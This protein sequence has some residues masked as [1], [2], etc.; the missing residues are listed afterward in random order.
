[1]RDER[2]PWSIGPGGLEIE[3]VALSRLFELAGSPLYVLSARVFDSSV[4]AVRGAL[5]GAGCR[6]YLAG[7]SNPNPFVWLR[8]RSFGVGLDACSPGE[9]EAALAAGF[10]PSEISFTGC[11]L[12]VDEMDFLAASGVELN[13]D[14]AD[15]ALGFAARHPR[16]PFGLRVN[17][18]EGAGSHASCTTAGS[19]AKLGTPWHEVGDLFAKLRGR[20]VPLVGL[21]CHT[22][23]G[24]L[25]VHHFVRTADRMEVLARELGGLDWLSLGGGLG[26]PHHPADPAFDLATYAARLRRLVESRPGARGPGFEVRLEPGQ[27][28]VA[29]A[30]VLAVTVVS[31]KVQEDGTRFALCDSSFNHYLGTSLYASYH[32]IIPDLAAGHSRPVR[33]VHVVGHLCNTGDVF[34]RARPLPEL[35][36]GDR[37]VMATCGAYGISRSSNYNT[38]PIP[39][40]VWVEAGE[41][42]CIRRRQ[43]VAE[44]ATWYQDVALGSRPSAAPTGRVLAGA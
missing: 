38:R 28:F 9:V 41:V 25:D 37:L 18:G 5:G 8:A 30:G 24:G 10:A 27:A 20:G 22:G 2:R 23:S 39:A 29:E 31:T 1:M 12:T 4:E 16:R 13:L 33:P 42:R 17:P 34:A 32:E 6:V 7:K 44:L 26:V 19:E 11:A 3:G 43:T 15:Q 36:V 40:E 21:H 14:A 35:R